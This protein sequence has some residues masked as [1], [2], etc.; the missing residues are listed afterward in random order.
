MN[1]AGIQ[2]EDHMTNVIHKV[3]SVYQEKGN[4]PLNV[5]ELLAC[6]NKRDITKTTKEELLQVLQYYKKLQVVFLN[7]DE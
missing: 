7:N 1:I 5:S 4:K 6:M 2:L 3:R